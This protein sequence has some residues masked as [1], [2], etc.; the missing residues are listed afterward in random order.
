MLFPNPGVEQH[1]HLTPQFNSLKK[2]IK[3]NGAAIAGPKQAGQYYGQHYTATNQIHHS[4]IS[5]FKHRMQQTH[6]TYRHSIAN[7]GW[8]LGESSINLEFVYSEDEM[9]Y[10][11]V[12]V[13]MNNGVQSLVGSESRHI[14]AHSSESTNIRFRIGCILNSMCSVQHHLRMNEHSPHTCILGDECNHAVKGSAFS[15]SSLPITEVILQAARQVFTS[16][17]HATDGSRLEQDGSYMSRAFVKYEARKKDR[18]R[19]TWRIW[20]VTSMQY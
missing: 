17:Y 11:L 13:S 2:Q 10:V 5:A 9:S 6:K 1:S 8:I 20:F 4:T 7:N 19:A 3:E 16:G 18:T 14:L 15:R 12:I